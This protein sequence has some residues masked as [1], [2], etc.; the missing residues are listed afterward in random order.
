M[1]RRWMV[2]LAA[3]AMLA[4]AGVALSTDGA[5]AVNGPFYTFTVPNPHNVFGSAVAAGD[6]NGDGKADIIVGAFN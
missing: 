3:C 4:I 2:G 1:G 6:V 5:A